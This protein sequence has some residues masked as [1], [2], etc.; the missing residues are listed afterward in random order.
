MDLKLVLFDYVI[1][2][3]IV[4]TPI[5]F[6]HEMGHFLI[7]RWN[8]VRVEVFSIGFG[9]EIFGWTDKANTRWKFSL[10]PLG[11]YIKMFGDADAASRPDPEASKLSEA[12][13]AV[14]FPYKRLSQRSWIVAGGPLA[15]FLFAVVLYAGL[16]IFVGQPFTPARVGEV[17]PD[18][19]AQEAGILA[20]DLF[21]EVDGQSIDRFEDIQRIVRISPGKEMA[22]EVLRDGETVTLVATPRVQVIEFKDGNKE[23][24]GLLGVRGGAQEYVQHDPLTAAWRA[25][26]ETY[27]F[28]VLMLRV[29]GQM[30]V[31]DRPADQLGGPL[32]IAKMAGQMADA[33]T[34]G[35]I[36]IMAVLSINLGLINLFPIPILD[37]G[38]LLYYGIEA[39]RGR[40][41]GERAQEYGFRIGLALVLS[42]MIFATWNDILRL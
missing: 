17:L 21:L 11:G 24:V 9:R 29:I 34:L 20:D 40:P 27:S 15:N 39:V 42:L 38:H 22:I 12:E 7:A 35:I 8:G 25:V 1:P 16:F 6:V 36:Q 30:I 28:T 10:I 14:A 37:G 32:G 33:G 41:L 18:S 2:F 31:G 26:E 23:E 5:V 13:R 3:L 19:A 4:L